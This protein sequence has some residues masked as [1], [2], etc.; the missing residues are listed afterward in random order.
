MIPQ[1]NTRCCHCGGYLEISENQ[2]KNENVIDAQAKLDEVCRKKLLTQLRAPPV[3]DDSVED[4]REGKPHSAPR[5]RLLHFHFVRL[6]LKHAEI[7]RQHGCD[8]D[9]ESGPGPTGHG[10]S[11]REYRGQRHWRRSLVN[12]LCGQ[13]AETS[14]VETT[15]FRS[16]AKTPAGFPFDLHKSAF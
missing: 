8:E 2:D 3:P 6:A 1:N 13:Q 12:A 10:I 11:K 16:T 14:P 5:E 7:E 15:A 9:E 4:H